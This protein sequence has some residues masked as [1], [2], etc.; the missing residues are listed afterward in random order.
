M[1]RT[2]NCGELNIN[3]LNETVTL[4]GWVQKVRN[5]GFMIWLDLRDQHGITQILF[6]H[7]R[8]SKKIFD[9]LNTINREYVLQINGIVIERISKNNQINTGEIEIL[10]QK[11]NI[12]NS[13]LT[14]PFTVENKTDGGE[15]LRM[16]YRFLDI[17]REEISK[18]IQLRSKINFEIRKFFN[19]NGFLD[20][21]TPYLIKSTPEGARDFIVPSRINKGEF[22]ALPQSPQTFKQLLVIG[23]IDKYFQIVKCFRDEDLRS[24]RQPEFTQIDC[25][26]S[27]VDQKDVM[28]IFEGFIKELFFRVKNIKLN[29]FPILSYEDAMKKYGSDKPD[30]RFDMQIHNL[31]GVLKNNKIEIFENNDSNLC[32]CIKEG[33]KLSRNQIDDLNNWVKNSEIKGKGF[34][35]IKY[36]HDGTIKSSISKL[37][38]NLKANEILK[39]CKG[40]FGDLIIL[41]SGNNKTPFIQ[42]GSLRIEIAK[43]LDLIKTK[44]FCPLWINDFPLFELDENTKKISSMHHPFT[45]PKVEDIELLDSTPENVYANSYDLVINGVEIGGGSIRIHDSKIQKKIFEILGFSKKDYLNQFGFLIEALEYGAPP[46]GGIAFGLDRLVALMANKQAIRDFIAFPKNN[47][48]KDIMIESPNKISDDQL[49]ELNLSI[50]NE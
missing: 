22:Y 45:S 50:N 43:R 39:V 13:S 44:E 19:K 28:N 37:I 49:N 29:D 41:V 1:L 48:G 7:E 34:M 23:G 26:M 2:H 8:T 21:E 14:P 5:K 15:E 27:F 46:H 33:A 36:N 3:N 12:L 18:N 32:I 31:N 25:E 16:K 4:C 30:I 42:L 17:R 24:D 10:A 38:D 35:W 20:I 11:I 47:S 6:D 40:N 9:K